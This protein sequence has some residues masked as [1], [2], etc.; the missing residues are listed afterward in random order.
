MN[1]KELLALIH[2][3]DIETPG[4]P[5]V[6]LLRNEFTTAQYN[7]RMLA[8]ARAVQSAECEQCAKR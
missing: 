8:I 6:G 1:D 5:M 2:R 7:A 3:V 4:V